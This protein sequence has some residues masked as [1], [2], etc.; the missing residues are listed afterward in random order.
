MRADGAGLSATWTVSE[1]ADPPRY[2]L[3][4]SRLIASV[5][6][7]SPSAQMDEFI[8]SVSARPASETTFAVRE[9]RELQ[10]SG[11]P[12]GLLYTTLTEGTG[13]DEVA[14]VQ[15][16][17]IVQTEANEFIVISSL[18]GEADFKEVAALLDRSYRSITLIRSEDVA[19]ARAARMEAG[20]HLITGLDEDALRRALDPTTAKGQLPAPRWYR[21]SRNLADGTVQEAGYMTMTVLEG[22]QGDANPDRKPAEWTSEEKE[23]GMLVRIQVRMLMDQEGT[24]LADTDSRYWLRW[25]RAREFWTSRTTGRRGRASH[26][27]SQLG[28]RQAPSRAQPRP[29]IE[30]A[31]VD[32]SQSASEPKRWPMPEVGYLSQVEA[33]VLPRL[34]PNTATAVD[35][36]FYWFDPRSGRLA[37]RLDK[38]T[39][40]A[41]GFLLATQPTLEAPAAEQ[42]FDARGILQKRE[43]EDGTVIEAIAPQSLLDLWRRK[44]LPTG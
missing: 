26:T 22:S 40:V 12:A 20:Q 28:L 15:G 35:Y 37:Q 23:L 17:L 14:A 16:Y 43:S 24:T 19:K 9:R 30:V 41:G 2:I 32:P 4:I 5:P 21:I 8:K 38:R 18:V 31:N 34:L 39:P 6:E 27:N 33:L 42:V 13:E 36:G 29:V 7:S 44:G 25:D 1:R 10:L 11:Q 3:R